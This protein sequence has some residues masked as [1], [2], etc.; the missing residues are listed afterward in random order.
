MKNKLVVVLIAIMCL[1]CTGCQKNA[2]QK[3]ISIIEK[4]TNLSNSDVLED[5]KN[6]Y[7]YIDGVTEPVRIE[8]SEN[9]LRVNVRGNVTSI[10]KCSGD[11]VTEWFEKYY[12]ETKDLADEFAMAQ[13]NSDNISVRENVVLI[14]LNIPEGT[15]MKKSD[16]VETYSALKDVYENE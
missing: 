12:F 15:V 11:I 7:D 6:D 10:Y 8:E 9:E 5:F 16:L 1:L 2:V 4:D 3:Q 13:E 14:K